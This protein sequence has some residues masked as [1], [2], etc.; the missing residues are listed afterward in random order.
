M[1]TTAVF[2]VGILM[3]PLS[4]VSEDA[5]SELEALFFMC[6][7]SARLDAVSSVSLESLEDDS[8]NNLLAVQI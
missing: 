1:S 4:F 2:P 3:F 6:I 8:L 7:Y 5:E